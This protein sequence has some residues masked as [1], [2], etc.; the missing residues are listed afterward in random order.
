MYA[1]VKMEPDNTMESNPC[2][3]GIMTDNITLATN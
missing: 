3:H 1:I 2:F